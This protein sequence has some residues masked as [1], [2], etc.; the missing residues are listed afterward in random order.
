[1]NYFYVPNIELEDSINTFFNKLSEINE[2]KYDGQLSVILL[3]SLSRGEGSWGVNHGQLILY[4]DIE[5]FTVVPSSFNKKGLFA[6]EI[7]KTAAECFSKYGGDL[8]H[9]DNTF[10][11][12]ESIKMIER[13]IL[14]FDAKN[15][16]KMMMGDNC[17]HIFP[18]I[19]IKNINLEDIWDVMIHRM[20]YVSYYG[21]NYRKNGDTEG[22]RYTIA[23][24][25]LDLM[26][27]L[28]AKH[29]KLVSGFRQKLEALKEFNIPKEYYDFFEYCLMI[30]LRIPK[31]VEYSIEKMEQMF[32]EIQKE[33]FGT[34][35]IPY[36]NRI[37]N[38]RYIVKRRLGILKRMCK[39]K[40]ITFGRNYFFYN[41]L[42]KYQK[43][44]CLT[45]RDLVQSY[46]LNGYPICKL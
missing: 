12:K 43:G 32:V 8:F 39:K 19:D 34:F 46:I 5:F 15:M 26:T 25:S 3:G 42:N 29:G 17:L 30:K 18:Y 21:T 38:W 11:E 45:D 27:V 33:L 44:E 2:T 40:T 7:Q 41:L 10:L 28:L 23:K 24:N 6:E 36:N 13:K 20:F 4:S 9:V 37:K 22:Y 16:G 31:T 14:T 35:N 1:M